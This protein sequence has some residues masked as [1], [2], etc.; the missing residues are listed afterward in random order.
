MST[1]KCTLVTCPTCR[2]TGKS[3]LSR[4]LEETLAKVPKTN[5]A[6]TEAIMLAVGDPYINRLTAMNNRLDSLT[7][8]GLVEKQ[9]DGR[10]LFWRRK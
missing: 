9:R 6:S 8:L 3:K 7:K 5:A 1:M 4:V 10:K 2:G